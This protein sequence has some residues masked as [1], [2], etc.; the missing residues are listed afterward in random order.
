M[1]KTNLRLQ[2]TASKST[3]SGLEVAQYIA[4]LLLDMRNLAKAQS[5]KTLQ[6]LL[7]ISYYEAFALAH[8]V[9]LPL[10]EKEHIEE[11]EKQAK[12]HVNQAVA[13]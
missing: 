3:Q 5:L 11:L 2:T 6:G 4:D 13:V 8:P 7:E 9:A 12:R 1:L 10:G